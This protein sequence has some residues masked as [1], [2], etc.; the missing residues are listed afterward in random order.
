MEGA[1][2]GN[3]LANIVYNTRRFFLLEQIDVTA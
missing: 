1:I 3:E 2:M